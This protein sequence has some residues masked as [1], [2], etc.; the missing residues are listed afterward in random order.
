MAQLG[1]IVTVESGLKWVVLELIGNAGGTQD[2]RLI[3]PSGDGRNTGL[4]KGASGLTVT[5]SPSFQPGDPVT[6]N[7]LKGSYLGTEDGVAHVL[8]A[9]RQMQTKS[10][11]FIGLDASVARMNIALL[12]IENRK[13]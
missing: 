2:A 8:L 5:A 3:R 11:A 1:D 12:V 10:G 13:L 9:P 7:G 4:L 6:V